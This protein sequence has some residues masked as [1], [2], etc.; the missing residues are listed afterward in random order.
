M[1]SRSPRL[2]SSAASSASR[3]SPLALGARRC[4][5]PLFRTRI[6]FSRPPPPPHSSLLRSSFSTLPRPQR[7]FWTRR[8]LILLGVVSIAAIG[9]VAFPKHNYPAEV[10]D[11]I[12]LGLYAERKESDPDR[13]ATALDYYLAALEVADKLG[14]DKSS[15]E[16]TGLQI[17][18]ASMLELMGAEQQAFGIYKQLLQ[19]G[20]EWAVTE[21]SGRGSAFSLFSLPAAQTLTYLRVC[22]R[23]LELAESVTDKIEMLHYTALWIDVTQGWLPDQYHDILQTRAVSWLKDL[24]QTQNLETKLIDDTS[25]EILDFDSLGSVTPVDE[26]P[27]QYSFPL[28]PSTEEIDKFQKWRVTDDVDDTLLLARD[29]FATA[30]IELLLPNIGLQIKKEN[31]RLM[32]MYGLSLPR[33]IRTEVDICS[34]YYIAY[35]LSTTSE[36]PAKQ[37]RGLK[38]LDTARECYKDILRSIEEIRSSPTERIDYTPEDYEDLEVSNSLTVYGLGVIEAKQKNYSEA[39]RLFKEA[40]SRALVAKLPALVDRI[41]EEWDQLVAEMTA[42]QITDRDTIADALQYL[43]ALKDASPSI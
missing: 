43:G 11:L 1:L 29:F 3:T 9:Y 6:D 7:K 10:A 24:Q 12:R 27:D 17:K 4:H 35:E 23:G 36:D 20:T 34:G 42:D 28:F 21:I 22:V 41:K 2:L 30:C 31:V 32:Q 14:M 40:R 18:A 38:L 8:K 37:A 16:Y 26:S 33:I 15:V 13:Y 25:A 39:M 5:L 19:F